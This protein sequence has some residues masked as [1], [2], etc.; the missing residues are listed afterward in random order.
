M[1]VGFPVVH[2]G[3]LQLS[4]RF[5]AGLADDFTDA[6]VEALDHAVGLRMTRR[7]QSMFDLQ[8]FASQVKFMLARR[9][10]G[11]ARKAVGELTA[12]VGEDDLDLHRRGALEAAHE[13]GAAGL[14]LVAVGAH[15]DPARGTIN[16]HKQVPSVP[17]I[18]H[19]WQ[20]F[21]VDVHE[22]RF[23]VLEALDG[24]VLALNGWLQ[25][26]DIG[27]A[28]A[29]QAAVQA[30][31]RHLRIDEL[32]AHRKQVVQAQQKRAAQLNSNRFL[33]AGKRGA[34]LVRPVRAVLRVLA[35]SP[36]AGRSQRDI[37]LLGNRCQRT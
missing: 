1:V 35:R 21:D 2:E 37:E 23:V 5:E 29:T 30:R 6:A 27:H 7:A 31:A 28:V 4:R 26:L 22:A 25:R 3:G 19:L 15:K 11:C 17:L 10:F 8:C 12:V 20:V 14:S 13:V 16:G 34:D 32:L 18:G 24:L 33:V 9:R 36:L